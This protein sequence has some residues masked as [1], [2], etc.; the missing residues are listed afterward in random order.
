MGENYD[1][2]VGRENPLGVGDF[3]LLCESSVTVG[4]KFWQVTVHTESLKSPL[5]QNLHGANFKRIR[6][7]FHPIAF[8]VYFQPFNGFPLDRFI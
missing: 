5:T 1:W 7:I 2:E 6:T 8:D 3:E 4:Q